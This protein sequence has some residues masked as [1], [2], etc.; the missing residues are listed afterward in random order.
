VLS[1]F[2]QQA[3]VL[4]E[5]ARLASDPSIHAVIFTPHWGIENSQVIEQRQRD[6]ARAAVEVGAIAVIGTHPH[7]LQPWEKRVAKDGREAL[8]IYST[9]NF[10]SAQREPKQRTGIIL[11]LEFVQPA[12]AARAR[13]SDARYVLTWI[14]GS[15][16][17]HVTENADAAPFDPLPAANR[18]R[19]ADAPLVSRCCSD[20]GAA[21]CRG[22]VR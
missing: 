22:H 15:G 5:I 1:C 8:V 20:D 2:R 16:V 6:L 14:D 17:P 18:V 3:E 10:I 12:G 7:V 13:I 9:G 11:L 21:Q 4:A 19:L